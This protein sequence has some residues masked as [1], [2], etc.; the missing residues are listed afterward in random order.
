MCPLAVLAMPPDRV[1]GSVAGDS[2]GGGPTL[3]NL[4]VEVWDRLDTEAPARCPVCEG[5]TLRAVY[6][7]HARPVMGRCNACG[8]ELR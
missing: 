5:G 8:A 4:I 1:G 3:D 7:A 2:R 6:G